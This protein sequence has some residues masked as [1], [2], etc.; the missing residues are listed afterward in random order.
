M[1]Y[2]KPVEASFLLPEVRSVFCIMAYNYFG[3]ALIRFLLK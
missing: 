1:G 2:I 3:E